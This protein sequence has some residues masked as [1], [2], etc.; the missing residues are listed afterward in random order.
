MIR[1]ISDGCFFYIQL[2]YLT[3]YSIIELLIWRSRRI[4]HTTHDTSSSAATPIFLWTVEKYLSPST[5]WRDKRVVTEPA[6]LD[7]ALK[8]INTTGKSDW[9]LDHGGADWQPHCSSLTTNITEQKDS[10]HTNKDLYYRAAEES[11]GVDFPKDKLAVI[12]MSSCWRSDV[13]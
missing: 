9:C 4:S 5:L 6:T 13:F 1:E 12:F 3:V 2:L 8:K 11:S 7:G 10:A